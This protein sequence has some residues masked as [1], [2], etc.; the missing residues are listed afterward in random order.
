MADI[1]KLVV[2]HGLMDSD[3]EKPHR[4]KT[5]KCVKRRSERGYFNNI[6]WELRIEDR[7]GSKYLCISSSMY[8][9]ITFIAN[10]DLRMGYSHHFNN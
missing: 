10:K 9:G 2:L 1:A 7:A 4:G 5:R 6:M 8:I 3:C